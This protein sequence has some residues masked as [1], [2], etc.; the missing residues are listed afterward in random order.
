MPIH[1]ANLQLATLH[2]AICIWLIYNLLLYSCISLWLYF[3]T[4]IT[5]YNYISPTSMLLFTILQLATWQF[6]YLHFANLQFT[7][8]AIWA[9]RSQPPNCPEWSEQMSDERMSEF[10]TLQNW[11]SVNNRKNSG[12]LLIDLT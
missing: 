6:A 10:P 8:V 3:A 4:F 2:F 9:I 5:C 7:T 12:H 1:F 11:Q